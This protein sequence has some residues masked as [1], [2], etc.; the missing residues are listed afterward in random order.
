MKLLFKI[1]LSAA[2][3]AVFA[4][5]ADSAPAQGEADSSGQ[6]ITEITDEESPDSSKEPEADA[7]ATE[8]GSSDPIPEDAEKKK[9]PEKTEEPGGSIPDNSRISGQTAPTSQMRISRPPNM[10]EFDAFSVQEKDSAVFKERTEQ[11]NE[12]L[13][14]IIRRTYEQRKRGIEEK[15]SRQVDYEEEMRN[16]ARLRAIEYFERFL[17]KYPDDPPYT[18]DAMFRLAEL[19][20]EDNY[21]NYLEAS[22][23]YI[24]L[25]EKFDRGELASEPEEPVKDY[26]RTIKLFEDLI[27]KYPDYRLIDGAYY[28][29]GFCLA[30]IGKFKESRVA[31]LGLV[32]S[33]KFDYESETAPRPVSDEEKME[34][35]RPSST[36]PGGTPNLSEAIEEEFFVNPY[37]DCTPIREDSKFFAETWLRVGEYHF[38]FDYSKYGLEKAISAYSKLMSMPDN[39][40]YDEALYKLAWTYYRADKY[41]ESIKHFSMLVDFSDQKKRETG[42][43]GSQMRPEAVQYLAICFSEEDWDGDQLPDEATGLQR[44]Q[45]PTYMPQDRAWTQEVYQQLGQI[46]FDQVKYP[47]AI[48][49]WETTLQKYP[50]APEAPKIQEQIATAYDR[51]REFENSLNARAKLADYGRDSKWWE[52]NEDRPEVQREAEQLAENALYDTAIHHHQVAMNLR[53]RGVTTQDPEMLERAVQEYNLA[54]RAYK[55]YLDTYPNR[56]DAYELNYNLA[57]AYYFSGQFELAAVEYAA[58]RDSNLD[59]KYREECGF[60]YIKS[61]E[62]ILAKAEKEGLVSI[63][64]E[65]PEPSGEPPTI[66]R[67][68]Y[69]EILA[70]LMEGR[71][72]YVKQNPDHRRTP[73]FRY[74]NARMEYIYGHWDEARTNFESIFEAYC[75]TE[76]GGLAWSTLVNMAGALNQLDEAERL[77]K[78]QQEKQ[79]AGSDE[80]RMKAGGEAVEILQTAQFRHAMEK[81]AEAQEKQ[82]N[83]MYEEAANMLVSAVEQNPEHPEAALAINNAAV[84]FERVQRFDSALKMYEKIVNDYPDSSFVDRALFRLAYSSF[85]F[86]EYEKA[87][88]NYLILAD[89][90]RFKDSEHREDA[91]RNAATIL[92]FLQRYDKAIVYWKK[93]ADITSDRALKVEASFRAASLNKETNRWS[94]LISEMNTFIKRFSGVKEAGPYIIHGYYLI[95]KGYV[96]TRKRSRVVSALRDIVSAYSRYNIKSGSAEAEYAAEADFLLIEREMEDFEKFRI[97]GDVDKI[98]RLRDEGAKKVQKLENEYRRIKTYGRPVWTV[99]AQYRIGYA[100]E[101]LAKAILNIPPPPPPRELAKQIK[102]LPQADRQM[103]IDQYHDQFRMAMEKLVT[104]MEER[105]IKEYELTVQLAKKGNISNKWTIEAIQRLN[106]YKPEQYSLDIPGKTAKTGIDTSTIKID[107]RFREEEVQ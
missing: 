59:D 13:T 18:P 33:N 66:E 81:F 96:E 51:S 61:L 11:F 101:I 49:V 12:V 53:Q 56:P 3:L 39:K 41:P 106:S 104:G 34:L 86:F 46:Y 45:D 100:Y 15:Y 57:D 87:I 75:A 47:Q 80:E 8:P 58:T 89:D 28:L 99:A 42:R 52:A 20:F 55:E 65:P 7:E 77:A 17:K 23:N 30:E 50:N 70:R 103:I 48:A 91:I 69:P 27:R 44:I 90:K 82:D 14:G 62:E 31:W 74:Q 9:K 102:R 5:H 85:K 29:L 95:Y 36:L 37:N 32:C 97:Y 10:N 72:I 92:T 22:E 38:D 67:F 76:A 24:D 26:S 71:E 43:T 88:D 73:P 6:D 35:D 79:C 83:T 60:K 25:L 64:E 21:V 19:Y 107:T 2:A 84:A 93:Y 16:L 40:Y 78:L 54:A 68:E 94:R 98:K 63:R 1:S 105:A 4:F